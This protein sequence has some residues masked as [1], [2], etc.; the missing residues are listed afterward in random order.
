[1]PRRRDLPHLF[2]DQADRLGRGDD[3]GRG[4]AAARSP[5]PS[6]KYIPAFA[7]M[8]VGVE[9]GDELDLVA[10]EAADHDPGPD[11]PHVRPDLRL[12]RGFAGAEAG[13]GAR[14]RR[15]RTGRWP[16]MSRR[17]RRCRCMHQ[18]GEVWEYSLSTDVLGRVV[19]VVAGAPLGDVCGSAFL[20]RS[21]WTTRRSSRRQRS[22]RRRAEPFSFDLHEAAGVDPSTRDRAAAD[23][24]RR[25]RPLVDARRLR[26]LLAMLSNGG[27]L[28]GA[29]ILGP[30]TIAYMASDHLGAGRRAKTTLLCPGMALGSASPCA[31]TPGLAPTAGS[32]GEYIWGGLAGTAFWVSPRDALF[33]IFMVQA[34]EH[35]EYFRLSCSATWSTPRCGLTRLHQTP[36]FGIDIQGSAGGSASPFWNSSIEILSGVRMKAMRP[37]RGGRL[38]VDARRPAASRKVVDVVDLVGEMAEVAPAAYRPPGPNCRS[39]RPAAPGRAR[40]ARRPR[41]RRGRPACSGPFR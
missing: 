17:S 16:S 15:A 28:D 18:P 14:T 21:A 33:A 5:I 30:R 24:S 22:L 27:A 9:N 38:I 34:P 12:H 31:R 25:R 36:V 6:A 41:A 35:R 8:K 11:A 4:R 13:H 23:A 20:R 1:M 29:R 2:D 37:S 26:A 7:E 19:E 40:P 3:A 10:A 39:A 32:V